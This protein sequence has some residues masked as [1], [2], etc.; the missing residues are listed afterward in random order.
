MINSKR[1][2]CSNCNHVTKRTEQQIR[3]KEFG[4]CENCGTKLELGDFEGIR[5]RASKDIER[6][7]KDL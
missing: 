1:F 3:D 2:K 6:F 4:S 7:K 5:N